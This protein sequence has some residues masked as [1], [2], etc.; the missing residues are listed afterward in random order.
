LSVEEEAA[1]ARIIRSP[2][3]IARRQETRRAE[4]QEKEREEL[5]ND[6]AA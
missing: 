3:A 6:R 2:S 5:E 1:V 4:R